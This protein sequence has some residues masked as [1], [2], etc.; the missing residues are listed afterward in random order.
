MNKE[1]LNAVPLAPATQHA[2]LCF[3]RTAAQGS[4]ILLVTSRDTGRW[5][6]PKGWPKKAETG[7]ES[8]LREAEEEAG[9]TGR[10][11]AGCLGVYNYDKT[12]PKGRT[13]PVGVLVH[14]VE[15][16]ALKDDY[17]ERGLRRRQWFAPEAA[18]AAVDEPELKVLIAHFAP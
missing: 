14:P 16:A 10:V 9:V 2:A 18:A 15:V 5:V 13:I 7:D 4:E 17:P 6:L 8:A 11:T 3:R 1:V 12:L